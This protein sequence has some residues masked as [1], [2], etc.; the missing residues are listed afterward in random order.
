MVRR[1][2]DWAGGGAWV[3]VEDLLGLKFDVEEDDDEWDDE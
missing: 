3:E 1:L 2:F